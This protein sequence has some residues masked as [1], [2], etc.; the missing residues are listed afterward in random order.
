MN[1]PVA[2]R[3]S[4]RL[5]ALALCKLMPMFLWLDDDG[6]VIGLGPTL[7]KVIGSNLVG[8]S[9]FDGFAINRPM[10]LHSID[11]IRRTNGDS[12]RLALKGRSAVAFRGHAVDL[13]EDGLLLNLSFGIGVMDAVGEFNLTAADFAVTDLAIE[14]LYLVEAKRAVLEEFKRLSF[15]LDEA[16]SVAEEK[17]QTDA[18]TGLKNRRALDQVL[19]KACESRIDF[20]VMHLD[21][22]RFK[23]VNDTLGHAAGDHVLTVVSTILRAETRGTDIIARIG[24]DEFVILLWGLT[25]PA[26]LEAL[27]L[28]LVERLRVPIPFE[29]QIC[30]IGASVGV[31]VSKSYHR[32]DPAILIQDAD[33]ALY[34]A[35]RAGRGR[36]RFAEVPQSR[37]EVS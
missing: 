22:D 30:Q 12:L 19:L 27:G 9:F 18:L 21:L 23:Q 31:T 10:G 3:S 35:K 33:A 25:D 36:V 20:A 32:L 2:I 6:M 26:L 24:G 17:A 34:D 13:A 15:R 37:P 14:L 11:D 4:A 28:R 1:A 16:R 29:G 8:Q 5:P 7:G